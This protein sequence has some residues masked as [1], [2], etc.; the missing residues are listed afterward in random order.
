[1]DYEYK[2]INK[3]ATICRKITAA[4]W[5]IGVMGRGRVLESI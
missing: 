3:P 1:M 2:K 4:S 5:N